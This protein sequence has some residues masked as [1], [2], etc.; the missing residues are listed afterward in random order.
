VPGATAVVVDNVTVFWR[1]PP[2][3]ALAGGGARPTVPTKPKA[4]R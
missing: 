1:R 3:R 2:A 4:A